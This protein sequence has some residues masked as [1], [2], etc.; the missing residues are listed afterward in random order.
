MF[1][2][3]QGRP[4]PSS[5]A[6]LVTRLY[7]SEIDE[8]VILYKEFIEPVTMIFGFPLLDKILKFSFL[9]QIF[10]FYRNNI[11]VFQS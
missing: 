4:P 1:E 10:N 9:K 5:L 7:Y 6:P 8:T 3:G 2:K 11:P